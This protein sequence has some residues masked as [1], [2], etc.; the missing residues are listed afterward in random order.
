MRSILKPVLVLVILFVG[1]GSMPVDAQDQARE[2]QVSIVMRPV[3]S[4]GTV[5]A[6]DLA[7]TS[8]IIQSRLA[9]LGMTTSTVQVK[10][11]QLVVATTVV[12]TDYKDALSDALSLI[13]A[14]PQPRLLEFVDL[15]GYPQ[16]RLQ[17]G[18]CILTTEQIGRGLAQMGE[19]GTPNQGLCPDDAAPIGVDGTERGAPFTTVMTSAGLSNAVA[20]N[21]PSINQWH[22]RIVMTESGS[23]IME[24][25]TAANLG[26]ALAIVLDGEVISV[27]I[28]AAT[29]SSESTISGDFTQDEAETLA[30]QIRSGVLPTQL[31]IVS[32]EI[33]LVE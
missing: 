22:I 25:H 26:Q 14:L 7:A 16:L 32:L 11:D 23:A 19:G 33:S 1:V 10:Q 20:V 3:A 27:P 12:A 30:V 8:D 24:A 2:W 4:A 15:A 28:I 31:E 9:G 13:D 6:E 18:D 21:D 5:S 29:I 17:A